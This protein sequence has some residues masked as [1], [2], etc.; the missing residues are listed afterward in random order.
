MDSMVK[1]L[2]CSHQIDI[3]VDGMQG[4]RVVPS[5]AD[6]LEILVQQMNAGTVKL[7]HTFLQRGTSLFNFVS[8]NHYL[9]HMI[10]L[11]RHMPPRLAWCDQGEDL[12]QKVKVLAQGSFRGTKP[13]KLGNKILGKYLVGL[14]HA[15]ASC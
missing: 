12:M 4:F 11:A 14:V 9:Y 5:E 13:R 1:V 15:L 6:Q 7:C 2:Q 10:Q 8:K 3:L